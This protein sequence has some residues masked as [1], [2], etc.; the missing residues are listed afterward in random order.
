MLVI[1][2]PFVAIQFHYE[3]LLVIQF[4]S[5]QKRQVIEFLYTFSKRMNCMGNCM[6]HCLST[7]VITGLTFLIKL[8]GFFV[9]QKISFLKIFSSANN[10]QTKSFFVHSEALNVPTVLLGLWS[11]NNIS[12]L[13]ERKKMK[14][15]FF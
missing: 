3:K 1:Q 13:N 9:G 8:I 15:F 12:K 2:F 10:E 4:H 11:S 6:G 14:N 7:R 5:M